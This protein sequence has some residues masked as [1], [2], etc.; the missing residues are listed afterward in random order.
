MRIK[1]ILRTLNKDLDT[2]GVFL[3]EIALLR[4]EN[5][6][7][8]SKVTKLENELKI[9]KNENGVKNEKHKGRNIS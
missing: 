9:A 8:R 6:S 7:L 2:N 5:E 3:R 1:D 4:E